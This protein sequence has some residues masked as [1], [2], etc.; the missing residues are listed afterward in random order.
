MAII[1]LATDDARL[2]GFSREK[3]I[4]NDHS[5]IKLRL[6]NLVLHSIAVN[7][8]SSNSLTQLHLVELGSAYWTAVGAFHP[9]CQASIV[10]IVLARQYARNDLVIVVIGT[11]TAYT[12]AYVL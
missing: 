1:E 6:L 2:P 4:L 8:F 5:R 7:D 12:L 9:W 10:Q 11:R 3:L